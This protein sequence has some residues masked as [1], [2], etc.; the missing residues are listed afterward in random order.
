L[1]HSRVVT[2]PGF[3]ELLTWMAVSQDETF[4]QIKKGQNFEIK[5]LIKNIF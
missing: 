3:T 4:D 2:E 5:F 1:T